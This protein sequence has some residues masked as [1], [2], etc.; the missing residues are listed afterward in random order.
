M[1][2]L[3]RNLDERIILEHCGVTI[4]VVVVEVRGS[5]VKL[6]IEAPKEVSIHREEVANRI[7]KELERDGRIQ[8]V[9]ETHAESIAPPADQLDTATR[10]AFADAEC[11]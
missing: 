9:T 5:S 1:L 2:V 7:N 11:A 10:P 4:E 8:P 3:K 6:G